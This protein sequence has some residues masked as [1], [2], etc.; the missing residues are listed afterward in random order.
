MSSKEENNIVMPQ[1]KFNE[2]LENLSKVN[3]ATSSSGSV[4]SATGESFGKFFPVG[5]A[6]L[7][8][9]VT[10]IN[11]G[12][13][14]RIEGNFVELESACWVAETARWHDTL[15]KGILN[16]VEPFPDTVVFNAES[17]IDAASWKHATKFKQS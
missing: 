13:V 4:T 2:I 7:I 17:L 8:R 1:E 9:T 5:S 12:V 15:A 11:I 16:E 3:G 6:V 10:Q 14:K